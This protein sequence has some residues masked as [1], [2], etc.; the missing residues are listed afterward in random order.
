MHALPVLYQKPLPS[1]LNAEITTDGSWLGVSRVGLS[2]H[3]TT[4]LHG[5]QAFPNLDISQ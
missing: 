4:G 2:Q 1:N 3:H 5:V